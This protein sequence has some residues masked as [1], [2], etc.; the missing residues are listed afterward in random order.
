MLD[1]FCLSEDGTIM[2]GADFWN[3][4]VVAFAANGTSTSG[5]IM[6]SGVRAVF[7]L[8]RPPPRLTVQCCL[9]CAVKESNECK[10]GKWAQF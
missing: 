1:D 7:F 4:T 8:P 2:Y 10:A 3:G 5:V 9:L 6:A